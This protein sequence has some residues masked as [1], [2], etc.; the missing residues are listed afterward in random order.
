MQALYNS[1]LAFWIVLLVFSL[2]TA[3]AI[4]TIWLKDILL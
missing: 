3:G 1:M 2:G 4:Y